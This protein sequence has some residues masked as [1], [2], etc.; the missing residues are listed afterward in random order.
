MQFNQQIKPF[1]IYQISKTLAYIMSVLVNDNNGWFVSA[2]HYFDKIYNCCENENHV[3]ESFKFRKEFFQIN[4]PYLMNSSAAK[5]S[6]N[7]Y[8][9]RS[10]KVRWF[11]YAVIIIISVF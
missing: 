6:E 1:E 3:V 4:T 7:V 2:K 11:L 9:S 8:S 5:I 10:K